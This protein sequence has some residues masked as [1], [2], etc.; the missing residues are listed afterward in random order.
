[1]YQVPLAVPDG[2][3]SRSDSLRRL[4]FLASLVGPVAGC[5]EG[6]REAAGAADSAPARE[7]GAEHA[8]MPSEV[9]FNDFIAPILHRS[10]VKCHRPGEAA[11]FPLLSYEDAAPRA[12]A[13]ALA[14]RTRRMPPWP[15][16][17]EYRHFLDENVLTAREIALLAAWSASG[18]ARGEGP[19]PEPPRFASGSQL[20]E[21]D[22][23]VRMPGTFR[24]QGNAEDHFAIIKLPFTV[25]RD[26]FIRAIEFVPGNRRLVHHMNASLIT[27]PEG[28]KRNPRAGR[29]FVL[30]GSHEGDLEGLQIEN[31]DGT[32]APIHI[33]VTNF[34]PGAN[35]V[36]YPEG[37]GGF[38][39]GRHNAIL[40]N[41]IHYGPTTTDDVD[42]SRFNIFF[43]DSAPSR[44]TYTLLLGTLGVSPVLPD[45]VIAPNAVETVRT[46]FTLPAAVS[47]LTINPHMHLLGRSFKAYAVL[48]NADTVP[49][50]SLPQWDFRWQYFYTFEQMVA[51]PAGTRI[52]A[53]GVYDNTS[54]NPNNPFTPPRE[55]RDRDGSMRT[56]DEM[57]QC[58]LTIVPYQAGDESRRL[59]VETNQP[60]LDSAA[61]DHRAPA[62]HP[63]AVPSTS[64]R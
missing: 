55:V 29:W 40:M 25:P 60:L 31:D 27:Y 45:L 63:A 41:M 5:G 59:K 17:P 47:I 33:G 8:A 62:G 34:L 24:I 52:V 50:V 14:T 3:P 26:T 46:E 36:M 11:P 15:A 23:V 61:R 54:G 48:P 32:F 42:S 43:A 1:L 20:G 35:P 18:A 64:K 16:D 49:L 38:R 53:E 7:R 22:L 58:I 37:L 12:S 6:G 2:K 56:T 21:P 10:C 30:Q 44:P 28:R 57:F 39:I 13:I 51:L 4:V 9:T 19:A